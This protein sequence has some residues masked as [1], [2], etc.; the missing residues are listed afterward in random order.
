MYKERKKFLWGVINI[1]AQTEGY[2]TQSNWTR[3]AHRSLV[4]Y[5]GAANDYWHHYHDDHANV[6]ELGCNALRITIEWARVEPKEGRYD[7]DAV[8]HYR[9]ILQDLHDR[10]IQTV[11][12]LWHWSIPIW[13]EEK[14]GMHQADVVKKFE[15]FVRYMRDALGEWI[16]IVV[17]L[18][19]P[20]VYVRTGYLSGSRPP[21]YKDYIKAYCVTRN[22]IAIHRRTFVIWKETY[23][24]TPVGSTHLWNDESGAQ[25]TIIQKIYLGFK[26]YCNVTFFIKRLRKYSD[27]LGINY[28]TSNQFFFGKSGG[29]WGFHG[30]N[31]WH[32][33]DV[34][35]IFPIGLYRVLINAKKF[36]TPIF[37]LENGKPTEKVFDDRDR[38]KFLLQCIEQMK[39]AIAQGAD[40]RG[41][42]HYSLCD[43]Y[44]WDSGYDFKFGL[45]EI[46]RDAGKR[47]KR[48]S[49][50]TYKK[51]I[52]NTNILL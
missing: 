14:F 12:G 27:F 32:H 49:F 17:V 1:G 34:W 36:N 24:E 38:Q 40:V 18:N 48:K 42:F 19:E 16:D 50:F 4:P 21:F 26:N 47:I 5:I 41:Y 10:N 9:E 43:S 23:P 20:A 52:Q 37:I 11:V 44:E 28:Y 22:L 15:N 30:T 13:C 33:P 46:D 29:K 3:W 31:D 45:I 2:D 6:E 25:D 35:K 39:C 51:I 8:S 7:A